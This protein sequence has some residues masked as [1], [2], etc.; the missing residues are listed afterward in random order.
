MYDMYDMYVQYIYHTTLRN[1]YYNAAAVTA[2]GY[3][4]IHNTP[5]QVKFTTEVLIILS[6]VQQQNG[7]CT[8]R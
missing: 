6:P 4:Y 5:R 7:G 1:M 2:V 3:I 8:T